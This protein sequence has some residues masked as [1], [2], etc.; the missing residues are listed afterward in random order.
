[1]DASVYS[2][3]AKKILAN[4]VP[5]EMSRNMSYDILP[6][7]KNG[8]YLVKLKSNNPAKRKGQSEISVRKLG[9]DIVLEDL[10]TLE[11]KNRGF[12]QDIAALKCCMFYDLGVVDAG[13]V[14]G[15]RYSGYAQ[16]SAV[17]V[18]FKTNK[19]ESP[20][21]VWHYF[22][23]A[24]EVMGKYFGGLGEIDLAFSMARERG[25]SQFCR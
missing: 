25:E 18:S 22:S 16:K 6:P 19:A 8:L 3:D 20:K 14:T 5:K 10:V 2:T 23:L 9:E 15:L 11:E 17:T 21:V 24:A 4:A 13:V 12:G 7:G 1:M